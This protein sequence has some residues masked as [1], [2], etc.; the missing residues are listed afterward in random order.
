MQARYTFNHGGGYFDAVPRRDFATVKSGRAIVVK[1]SS[2]W[3]Q[4][5]TAD[6]ISETGAIL[7]GIK[8]LQPNRIYFLVNRI[9]HLD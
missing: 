3:L 2:I 4:K 9:V 7:F 5:S 6:I 8:S 1:V